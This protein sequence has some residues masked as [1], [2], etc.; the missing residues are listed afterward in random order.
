M[1][2]AVLSTHLN[3]HWLPIYM[4]EG[5]L[6]FIQVK[7]DNQPVVCDFTSQTLQGGYGMEYTSHGSQGGYTGDFITQNSQTSFTHPSPG[8][9]FVSQDFLA[10]GS[11][12]LFTQV[13]FPDRTQDASST[14]SHFTVGGALQPQ[15]IM[16]PIYSQ[17]FTQYSQSLPSQQQQRQHHQNHYNG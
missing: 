8:T 13:S 7:S 2:L 9:D 1:Y 12:G 5:I 3:I 15:G 4:V 6:K 17:P 14:Q 16:G 10:H 11:Q